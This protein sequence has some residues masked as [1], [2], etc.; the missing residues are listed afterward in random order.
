MAATPTRCL[1]NGFATLDS[2]RFIAPYWQGDKPY[3][4]QRENHHEVP[5]SVFHGRSCMPT[6]PESD[7]AHSSGIA[8]L[9]LVFVA[10]LLR[11]AVRLMTVATRITQFL[12][13]RADRLH[14]AALCYL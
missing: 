7:S 5:V 14:R 8:R 2:G 12:H 6:E 3:Q 11:L 4:Q 13:L 9:G 10:F 1:Q